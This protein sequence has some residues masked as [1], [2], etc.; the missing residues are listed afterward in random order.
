MPNLEKEGEIHIQEAQRSPQKINQRGSIPR[1]IA[2][3]IVRNSEKK[4][5]KATEENSYIQRKPQKAIS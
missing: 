5:L 3:K 4:V 2:I 1:H